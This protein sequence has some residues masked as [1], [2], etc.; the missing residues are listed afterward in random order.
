MTTNRRNTNILEEQ[1]NLQL[2]LIAE[3]RAKIAGASRNKADGRNVG[4]CQH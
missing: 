2:L 4:I 1:A 3:L